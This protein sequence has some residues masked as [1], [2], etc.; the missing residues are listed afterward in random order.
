MLRQLSE[1]DRALKV[2]E[3]VLR[4]E[5]DVLSIEPEARTGTVEDLEVVRART[6]EARQTAKECF[7][8]LEVSWRPSAESRRACDAA[9]LEGCLMFAGY[10]PS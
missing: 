9:D 8:E 6:V 10:R 4:R 3:K 2:T 5:Y 7:K 1:G